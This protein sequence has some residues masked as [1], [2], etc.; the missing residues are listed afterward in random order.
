MHPV[1]WPASC[2]TTHM[3][4]RTR[5][6][7]A[8][9]ILALALLASCG[10]DSKGADDRTLGAELPACAWPAEFDDPAE[11]GACKAARTQLTCELP[12]GATATCPSDGRSVCSG[13]DA[14]DVEP[15]ACV[16]ECEANEYSVSCG[17]IGV[18]TV[19]EPPAGCR[20]IGALPA[21]VTLH[22][23]PCA[24]D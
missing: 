15:S 7:P 11:R 14:S 9:G 3:P 24:A 5:P 20:M 8:H 4:P 1:T 13:L 17:G 18:S 2:T 16:R 12:G 23:C 21:G 22:C 10:D 6:K 19:P